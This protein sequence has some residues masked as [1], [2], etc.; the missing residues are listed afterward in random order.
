VG[1]VRKPGARRSFPHGFT[2]F[3]AA[4]STLQTQQLLILVRRDAGRFLEAASNVK[5]RQAHFTREAFERQILG[6]LIVQPGADLANGRVST[7]RA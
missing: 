4:T 3:D 6:E 2:A 5:F 1:F 7:G